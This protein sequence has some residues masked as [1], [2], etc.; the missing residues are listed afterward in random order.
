MRVSILLTC[1]NHIQYLPAAV[2]SILAQ[3]YQDFEI[4]A[5]DDGSTDG[6]RE[7][8]EQNC[9]RMTLLFNKENLGTYGALNAGLEK[10]Q[11]EF[12][13]IFNDDDLWSP[14]KL[15]LQVK[16]MDENP[17]VGLVHTNGYFID[18]NGV[19]RHDSPLGFTFPRT[20]TGDVLLALMDANKIIASA[21]L[22]RKEC[23]DTLG[24][25]ND[26]YFGSGDWEMWYRIAEKWQ[27]GFVDEPLTMYRVHGG[28]ASHRLPQIWSDDLRLRSWI[29]QRIDSYGDRFNAEDLRRAKAHNMACLGTV[30]M[31]NGKSTE[32]RSAYRESLKLMPGRF[33]SRLRYLS[34][35]LPQSIFR[36]LI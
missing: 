22:A 29:A 27:V 24:G 1:Y 19:E 17:Q 2:E 3:T 12:V 25:F 8:L 11:G 20:A 21:V 33:K 10:A 14:S 26:A 5:I 34:T 9:D 32:A 18:A 16:M 35:Y 6:S 31:L 13:A 36:K 7:W 4:I 15:E 30:L 28:N 23:F